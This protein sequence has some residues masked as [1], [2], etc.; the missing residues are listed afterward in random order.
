MKNKIFLILYYLIFINII[1][2]FTIL[3][4]IMYI[5]Y[6]G[7][8]FGINSLLLVINIITFIIFKY[9]LIK[10]KKINIENKSLILLSTYIIFE[11]I[12]IISCLIFDTK[13]MIPQ[14]EYSYYFSIAL[15]P[16][17]LLNIYCILNTTTQKIAN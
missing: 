10:Y 5:F 11:I 3:N 12:L 13:L 9:I 15:I 8:C 16:Y 2:I 7:Y 6:E 4:K 17:T 14:I 1:L